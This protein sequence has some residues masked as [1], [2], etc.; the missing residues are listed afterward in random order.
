M[1]DIGHL[2]VDTALELSGGV[3]GRLGRREIVIGPQVIRNP[4]NGKRELRGM[5]RIPVFNNARSTINLIT[6]YSYAHAMKEQ[7]LY[8]HLAC[9]T[10]NYF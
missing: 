5:P 10:L 1:A 7:H 3:F 4:P 6:K 2:D 8:L 9:Q